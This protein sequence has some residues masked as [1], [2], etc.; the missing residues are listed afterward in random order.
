MIIHDHYRKH[1][2]PTI[3]ATNLF[4]FHNTTNPDKFTKIQRSQ[5][6]NSNPNKRAKIE[7]QCQIVRKQMKLN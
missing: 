6:M 7:N 2:M 5:D 1:Q 3:K 4:T